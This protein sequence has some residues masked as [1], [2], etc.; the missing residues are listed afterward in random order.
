M[1]DEFYKR[2][3]EY[4]ILVWQDFMFACVGVKY[5]DEF[6][7]IVKEEITCQ[8]K[9]LRNYPCFALWAGNNESEE[10]LSYCSPEEAEKIATE[11]ID[12]VRMFHCLIPGLMKKYHPTGIYKT[13]SPT[14]DTC[15][16][17]P[18]DPD[19]G[20]VH[21]WEVWHAL[22]PFSEYRKHL[23]RFCSEFG[24]QSLPCIETIKTFADGNDL[25]LFSP[26]MEIHQ[27]FEAGNSKILHYLAEN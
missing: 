2:C 7:E 10:M 13:S 21:F 23:F 25:N 22:K 1:D 4:G 6:E 16:Y 26:V 9:R 3:C 19:K 5:T 17:R 12:Y 24:F 15:F 8:L 14:S 27:K 18:H 20:D 11:R